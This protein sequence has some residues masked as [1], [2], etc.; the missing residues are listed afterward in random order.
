MGMEVAQPILLS[1][2]LEQG[3]FSDRNAFLVF[4][5]LKLPF[6]GHPDNHISMLIASI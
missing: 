6:S 4:F 1:G 2:C 5:A 3:H